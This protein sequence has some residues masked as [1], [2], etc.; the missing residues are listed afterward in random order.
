MY[1]G[2]VTA[3]TSSFHKK[4]T[5]RQWKQG[6]VA[7]EEYREAVWMCRDGIR[8]TKAQ[9]GLNLETDIKN[10]KKVFCR[11][12]AQKKKGQRECTHSL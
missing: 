5:N 11:Y 10:N 6:C 1:G 8:N 4:E 2:G 7:W 12:F 9:M 3:Y